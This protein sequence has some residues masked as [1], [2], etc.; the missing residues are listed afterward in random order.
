MKKP[1]T[2]NPAPPPR[3]PHRKRQ[4]N[5]AKAIQQTPAIT[6]NVPLKFLVI[7]REM[8]QLTTSATTARHY[9]STARVANKQYLQQVRFLD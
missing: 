5:T 6:K 1:N 4:M 9:R 7:R 3:C 8:M 2:C